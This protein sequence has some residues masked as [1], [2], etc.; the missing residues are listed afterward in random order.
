MCIPGLAAVIH[1]AAISTR[2]GPDGRHF[3]RMDATT[4]VQ[5]CGGA[6]QWTRLRRLGVSEQAVR[7]A[8]AHGRIVRLESGGYA[9]A[10]APPGLVAAVA[11]GGTASHLSAARL[12][13]LS[14]WVPPAL[15]HVTIP[16][17]GARTAPNAV[18][19]PA[20]LSPADVEA[21][22]AVTSLRRTLLDCGR[23]LPLPDGVCVLDS[24][25]RERLVTC[26][27]L[28]SMAAA[29]RGPGSAN[30]RRAVRHIDPE[31]QSAL[32]SVLRVLLL[33]CTGVVLAQV[34]IS[35]V[36]HVD[37]LVNGWLVV[38]GDGFEFHS[39]REAYREDRRRSNALTTKGH[40]LL[41]FT[42]EDLRFRP[43]WVVAQVE[44]AL[45][46]GRRAA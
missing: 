29:A 39:T 21:W 12:H 1:S 22:R 31:A 33:T 11:L 32:E 26:H 10:D 42:W 23:S 45:A 14:V 27:D 30:V 5:K 9:T 28:Q 24:A 18:V 36:G 15:A 16:R 40:A 25:L 2:T 37:F 4:A 13:G 17:G 8:T 7:T 44:A 41:R 20:T 38:E 35:G 34:L 19:H 43:W 3:V 6:A 46:I